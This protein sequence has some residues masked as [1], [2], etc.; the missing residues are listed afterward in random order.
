MLGYGK[1][2]WGTDPDGKKTLLF[3]VVVFSAD[4]DEK[5]LG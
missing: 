1:P 3:F 5:N 2:D 4:P